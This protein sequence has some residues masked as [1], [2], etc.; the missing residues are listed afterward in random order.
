MKKIRYCWRKPIDI[1]CEVFFL[2]LCVRSLKKHGNFFHLVSKKSKLHSK[3]FWVNKINLESYHM[4]F[5]SYPSPIIYIRICWPYIK[6]I[7]AHLHLPEFRVSQLLDPLILCR[8]LFFLPTEHI[9]ARYTE[10]T[11]QHCSLSHTQNNRIGFSLSIFSLATCWWN[12]HSALMPL[13]ICV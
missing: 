2:F 9:N 13:Y 1:G 4:S 7:A 6:I 5:Y 3:Y 12:A 10:E 11:W 8:K